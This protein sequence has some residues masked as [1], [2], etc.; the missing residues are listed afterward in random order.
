[1]GL[2]DGLNRASHCACGDVSTTDVVH[3]RRVGPGRLDGRVRVVGAL[4]GGGN[5]ARKCHVTARSV[6]FLNHQSPDLNHQS[7]V[8]A[9]S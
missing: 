4:F 3:V 2:P 9:S 6:V 7:Q 8:Q 5:A 1:V